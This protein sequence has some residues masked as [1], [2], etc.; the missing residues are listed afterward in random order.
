MDRATSFARPLG[1]SGVKPGLDQQGRVVPDAA[2]G[3]LVLRREVAGCTQASA[4]SAPKNESDGCG[5]DAH[6][7]KAGAETG[8]LTHVVSF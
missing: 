6:G 2:L 5:R 3:S 8:G 4:N 1:S 7:P